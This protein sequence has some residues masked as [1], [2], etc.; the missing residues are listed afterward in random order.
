MENTTNYSIDTN[1]TTC[2]SLPEISIKSRNNKNNSSSNNIVLL[3][4]K[5]SSTQL[6]KIDKPSDIYQNQSQQ[7]LQIKK[8]QNPQCQQK[9]FSVGYTTPL[10]DK[11]FNLDSEWS[12]IPKQYQIYSPHEEHPTSSNKNDNNNNN[13]T[14]SHSRM[15]KNQDNH[16]ATEFKYPVKTA[17]AQ[18]RIS[19]KMLKCWSNSGS[20]QIKQNRSK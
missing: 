2:Y 9:Q 10:V 13:E 17:L 14:M 12:Q 16:L 8:L 3:D 18:Q 11:G 20:D 4:T 7:F 19:P 1:S 6:A 5:F 15:E